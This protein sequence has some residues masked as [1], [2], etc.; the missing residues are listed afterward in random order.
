MHSLKRIG[1][2]FPL[3]YSKMERKENEISQENCL[4]FQLSIKC[5]I[6]FDSMIHFVGERKTKSERTRINIAIKASTRTISA[7]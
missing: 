5:G 7:I 2:L 6:I 1:L 3:L 4:G